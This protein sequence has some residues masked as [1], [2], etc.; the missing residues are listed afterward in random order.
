MTTPET[1]YAPYQET[2]TGFIAAIEDPDQ[3]K[4]VYHWNED[5]YWAETYRSDFI[6]VTDTLNTTHY[7]CG[8]CLGPS[9]I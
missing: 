2:C 3:V 6:S 8:Y 7:I 9:S 4:K 1:L 5:A